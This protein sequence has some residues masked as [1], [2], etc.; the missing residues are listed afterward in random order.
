M[1]WVLNYC[2]VNVNFVNF[3]KLWFVKR[4]II[5]C[6]CKGIKDEIFI[7]SYLL[8]LRYYLNWI[9]KFCIESEFMFCMYVIDRGGKSF[10]MLYVIYRVYYYGMFLF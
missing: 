3:Y 4:S 10:F 2:K 6:N 5:I 7:D 8:Y 9:Y 1:R